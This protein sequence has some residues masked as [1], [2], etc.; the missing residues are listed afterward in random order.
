LAELGTHRKQES[1]A[2]GVA[3]FVQYQA[4]D[5]TREKG[6]VSPGPDQQVKELVGDHA[7][8]HGPSV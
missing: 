6:A 5:T 8:E 7:E 3:R 1:S 2:I 4:A